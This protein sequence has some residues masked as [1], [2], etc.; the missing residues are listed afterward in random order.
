MATYVIGDVQGCFNTL[1]A[2][3]TRIRY[4]PRADQLWF[5][6]DLVNRGVGSL[7]CL[8]FVAHCGET[9]RVVLGNH[10]LHLLAVAEGLAAPH[11]KDT[12]DPILA[13]PDAG[14]LLD[15]LRHQKLL[16]VEP[17]WA[18]VHAGLMPSWNWAMAQTLAR[19]V[20][21]S[22]R[23]S[24]YRQ[25]LKSMYGNEPRNWSTAISGAARI[26]FVINTMTRM[27]VLDAEGA[28]AHKFKGVLK[29]VPENQ[30]AWFLVPSVRRA[31]RTLVT[32]HWSALGLHR[33]ERVVSIDTGCVWGGA[34]TALRLDDAKVF[35]QPSLEPNVASWRD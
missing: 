9:T 28:H 22:L 16:H 13:A 20:E 17:R 19:E 34:L 24:H 6:G 10:D 5:V 26:R 7:E 32:G 12:L 29:D 2:L 33:A 14:R 15:W 27:R 11:A 25:T 23:G 31:A 1:E 35:Q 8:R 4:R 18:M 21:D 30:R 3:L